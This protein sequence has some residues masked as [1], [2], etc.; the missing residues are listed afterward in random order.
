[1]RKNNEDTVRAHNPM[2]GT[3]EARYNPSLY[4]QDYLKKQKLVFENIDRPSMERQQLQEN[5]KMRESITEDDLFDQADQSNLNIQEDEAAGR[6][7]HKVSDLD[8]KKRIEEH[9]SKMIFDDDLQK[10]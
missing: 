1:M 8:L 2:E 7:P 5:I 9:R 6:Q 4:Q 3:D 10:S